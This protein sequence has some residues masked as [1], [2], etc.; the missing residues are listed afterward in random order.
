M[1]STDNA[2]HLLTIGGD[3][4]INVCIGSTPFE[5]KGTLYQPVADFARDGAWHLIEIPMSTFFD[6]G[7]AYT[8]PTSGNVV[9]FL[10]GGTTGTKLEV[11][12]IFFYKK[13]GVGVKSVD[14]DKLNVFVSDK[15]LT[16][17]GATAPIELYNIAGAKVK[18]SNEA[19]MGIEDLQ[20]GIYIVRCGGL[21]EKVQIK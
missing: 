8:Q 7:L 10:S 2:S 6:L 15:T 14:A 17:A 19:I 5:D 9:A 16:V 12:A 21:T 3:T 11:D 4:D 1:K 13:F 18:V 20:S